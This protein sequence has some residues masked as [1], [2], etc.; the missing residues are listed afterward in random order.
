SVAPGDRV[1][2]PFT[3]SCGTCDR[4]RAGL[5]SRCR[6]GQLFG[7]GDPSGDPPPLH[8]AQAERLRVP[9][10]DGTL[11]TVPEAVS[12]SAA[13]LLADNFPTGWHAVART[14]HAADSLAVIGLGAVGLCAIAAARGRGIQRVVGIDP[15]PERRHAAE[16]LRAVAVSPEDVDE[17]FHAIVESAGPPSAQE[18]AA[19]ISEPGATISMISAQT[20][21]HFAI[22]PVTAYDKN[23]TIRTGRAPVR[24]VL[25]DL[26]PRVLAGEIQ[27]P[28]DTVITHPDRP[29]ADGPELYRSFADRSIL[30]ASFRPSG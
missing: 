4:C 30:K 17:T 26:L 5:S 23:L 6:N 13:L 16:S 22:D 7:W 8:G 19:T 1:I 21:Q 3:T 10:A 24:S 25:D 27:V 14:D 20:A 15:I 28:S 12:D 9:L 11:L 18:L 2:V 29:L